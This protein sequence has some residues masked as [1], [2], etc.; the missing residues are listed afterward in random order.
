MQY[1]PKIADFLK[2]LTDKEVR[3]ILFETHCRKKL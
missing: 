1:T 2:I 3:K